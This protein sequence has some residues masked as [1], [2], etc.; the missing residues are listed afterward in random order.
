MRRL[1]TSAAKNGRRLRRWAVRLVSFYFGYKILHHEIYAAEQ[2]DSL[3]IALGL[4]LCGIAPADIFD[5]LRKLGDKVQTEG[6]GFATRKLKSN[7]T[8]G[9][10]A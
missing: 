8:T 1:A 2:A 5:G 10:A 9:D 3:R 7:G 4:W 6:G